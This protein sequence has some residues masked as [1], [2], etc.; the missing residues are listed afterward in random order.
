MDVLFI[1]VVSTLLSDVLTISKFCETNLIL[2]QFA[3]AHAYLPLSSEF[4][5]VN[6]DI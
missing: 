4:G 1:L 2:I 3:E 5:S 6:F